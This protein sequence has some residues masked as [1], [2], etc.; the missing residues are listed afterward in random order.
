MDR[1]L[2]PSA[3]PSERLGTL[4]RRELIAGASA[5]AAAV[6]LEQHGLSAEVTTRS[7]AGRQNATLVFTNTTVVNADSVQNDVALAVEGQSIVAIG[8]T[9]AVLQNYPRA[10]LYDGRGKALLPGLINCHAHMS[11]VVERGFNEDFGFPNTARLP[12]SPGSLL[13]GDER[14]LM[15]Q[16]AALEAIRT[17]TTTIVENVGN[18]AGHASALA[19]SGLRCVFA[20]S[21]RDAENVRG[22]MMPERYAMTEDPRFSARL[23]DEGMQRIEDLFSAWH[24]AE[25][26]RI[27]VFPAAGLVE[28]SSPE[29]LQAVRAFAEERGVGYTIHLN[30]SR[31]EFEFMV[32]YHGVRPSEYLAQHDF[33]GPRLF[34]AHARY[35]ND[36]EIALLGRSRT[37]ISHQ[38]A[39]AANRGV[40]PPIPALRAAGCNMALG[41]DNNTNDLFEVM[42]I[43]LVTERI[44][45]NRDGDDVPGLQPQPEDILADATQGGAR[46]VQQE[47]ELGTLEVGKK[48]DLLVI[49]TQR[50]HLVPAGRLLSAV[51]HSGHPGDIESVMIDGQFVMR[52]REVTTMDEA[53]IIQEADRV[54]KRIWSRV[55]EDGEVRV[56]RLP[57]GV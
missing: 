52:D 30:Q 3:P 18:I 45:R 1:P 5:G 12:T 10:A 27:S 47:E 2:K 55:L 15:V 21:V 33:L 48:A 6:F 11:A 49:D 53:A 32:R 37:T 43:A 36:E 20:E 40:S 41:T 28:T 9:D 35:V 4:S 29:L 50:A 19:A 25:N 38:A 54:G 42:R 14:A 31:A 17:G 39:M 34:A 46:A 8:P 57:R 56:P 24:G 7:A 13:E 23:R 44:R 22:P 26:G 51:V 16:V